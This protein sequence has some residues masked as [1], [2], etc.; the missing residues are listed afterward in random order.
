MSKA[1]TALVVVGVGV[2]AVLLLASTSKASQAS[3]GSSPFRFGQG[4]TVQGKSG[5]LWTTAPVLNPGPVAPGAGVEAVFLLQ[6]GAATHAAPGELVLMFA[7]QGSDKSTRTLVSS[8]G[9]SDTV[10]VARADFG[11]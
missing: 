7:Q 10:A 3:S 9:S 8:P 1:V 5:W 2:G 11:V 6:A 4:D